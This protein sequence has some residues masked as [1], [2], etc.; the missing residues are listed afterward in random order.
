MSNILSSSAWDDRTEAVTTALERWG[1]LHGWRTAQGF[2][3]T[4]TTSFWPCAARAQIEVR[5]SWTFRQREPVRHEGRDVR[6]APALDEP[7]RLL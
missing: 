6:A 5:L 3:I 7:R 1:I 4:F 2:S